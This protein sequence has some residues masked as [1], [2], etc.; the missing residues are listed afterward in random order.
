[1]ALGTALE[2]ALDQTRTQYL[3]LANRLLNLRDDSRAES[4]KLK[5]NGC[6]R[7]GTPLVGVHR[8]AARFWGKSWRF[9]GCVVGELR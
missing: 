6:R 5:Q 7:V 4:Q 8:L 1:M 9:V 3:T 2:P